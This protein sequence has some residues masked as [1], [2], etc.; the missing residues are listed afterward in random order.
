MF[1]WDPC[2]LSAESY[3]IPE[4]SLVLIWLLLVL[5]SLLFIFNFPLHFWFLWRSPNALDSTP[6]SSAV[7]TDRVVRYVPP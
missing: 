6:S 5:A 7:S 4:I 2:P 3:I 1:S